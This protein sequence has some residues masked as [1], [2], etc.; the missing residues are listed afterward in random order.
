[1]AAGTGSSGAGMHTAESSWI[2][3]VHRLR[4]QYFQQEAVL[5]LPTPEVIRLAE[6]QDAIYSQLF[7]EHV[8]VHCPPKRYQAKVLK[9]LVA[10]IEAAIVDWDTYAVSD[11]LMTSL[12]ELMCT[13]MPLESAVIQEKSTVIY[14][15]S[16]LDYSGR[17]S[18]ETEEEPCIILLE[19][20]F[21]LSA[22][23]TT[24]LR[25]WEAALHLGQYLSQY[26]QVVAGRRVLELGAGTGYLSM[27][28]AK[29]LSPTHV[30][31]SDGSD[32]VVANF[33][34]N[35][36]LNRLEE[37]PSRI[38]FVKLIWG[39]PL[40]GADA[41][42]IKGQ[43]VDVILGADVTYDRSAIPALVA[44]LAEILGMYVHAQAYV[45]ITRRSED[46]F[47][48]FLETCLQHKLGL[49]NLQYEIL[50]RARQ[51]GPFYCD[52]VEV[53]VYRIQHKIK[54][55]SKEAASGSCR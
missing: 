16:Q 49:E 44:S 32:N 48:A 18:V 35:L 45:A 19:S 21:L 30:T 13:P 8:V 1:M 52:Q 55:N 23:G 36:L 26:P 42:W 28:C 2:R 7:D 39:H 53:R 33:S 11:S 38:T 43:P 37:D 34:N 50:P 24:G 27:L 41:Q 12:A 46:N 40:I 3:Q 4:H 54:S 5:D 15:L 29:Y 31:L 6:V 25:T 20:R 47:S 22:A 17:D 9:Q 14:H 51:E 10:R